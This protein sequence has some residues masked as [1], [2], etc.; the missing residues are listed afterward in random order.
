[1]ICC[2][3]EYVVDNILGLGMLDGPV[4]FKVAVN[5]VGGSTPLKVSLEQLLSL[6]YGMLELLV[7]NMELGVVNLSINE[8]EE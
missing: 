8:R 2:S 3:L 5:Q 1:M 6:F 4:A 7:T